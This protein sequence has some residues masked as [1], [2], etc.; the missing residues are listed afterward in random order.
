MDLTVITATRD[1]PKHLARV[2]QSVREQRHPLRVE[3]LVVGDGPNPK[4]RFLAEQLG[5]RYIETPQPMGL[6]G[7][8]CKD[9]GIAAAL[10][11]YVVFWDDDNVYEPWALATMYAIAHG[12]DIGVAQCEWIGME[13]EVVRMVPASWGRRPKRGDV[14][15]MCVCVRRLAA[16]GA[17]W[18]DGSEDRGT[19]YRW[20]TRLI[21]LKATTRFA[22]IVIG[23]HL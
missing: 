14:D 6:W 11:E 23:K 7:A 21:R 19:D 20:L 4:S 17:A 22:P 8:G 5:V 12:H 18:H 16:A 10:G 9:A 3:H 2:I 1:R 15:T 13:K